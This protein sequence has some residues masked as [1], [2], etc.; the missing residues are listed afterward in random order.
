MSRSAAK[1]QADKGGRTTSVQVT[2]P[3]TQDLEVEDIIPGRLTQ[4]QW[5]DM[6]I[7]EDAEEAVCEIMEILLSQVMEGCFKAHIKSQLAPFSTS[8][9]KYYLVQILERQFLCRD[10]GEGAEEASKTE[11]SEPMPATP[12]VWAQ[13]CF[14]IVHPTTSSK[15]TSPQETD[16]GQA[17]GQTE[18]KINQ[19]CNVMVQANNSLK[20][21]AKEISLSKPF[22]GRRYKV[23]SPHSPQQINQKKKQQDHI[24]P[25][26]VPSKFLPSLSCSSEKKDMEAEGECRAQSVHNR[27]TRSLHRHNNYQSMPKLDHSCLPQ[28]YVVPQYEIL[29]NNNTKPISRKPNQLSKLE[30]RYNK[31]QTKW[32]VASSKPLTIYENQPAKRRNEAD[33]SLRKLFP[34]T[35]RREEMMSSGF[36]RLDAMHFAKGVSLLDPQ[37]AEINPLEF[38]PQPQSTKLRPIQSDAAL[39]LF[40]VDQFTTGPPPQVTPLFQS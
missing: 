11:D 37:A 33:V 34:S 40:S 4:V 2:T 17:P 28:H 3:R 32:T 30:P 21:S 1:S 31:Q 26:L 35:H 14:P 7:Q 29:D 9:A 22:S 38:K 36:L 15:P 39:P 25:K 19:Q 27:T 20:Q 16:I 5:T 10:E 18:P 12:D 8:W 6:F 13:G 24:F 23:L